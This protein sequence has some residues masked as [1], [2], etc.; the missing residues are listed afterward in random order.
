MDVAQSAPAPRIVVGIDGSPAARAALTWAL[1]EAVTWGGSVEVVHAWRDPMILVPREYD[2]VLVERDQM[3]EASRRLLSEEI[4]AV[5]A[6]AGL[7]PVTRHTARG[8]AANALIER[9]DGATLVVVGR[10]GAGGHPFLGT[11]ADQVARHAGC[12]VAVVPEG[13]PATFGRVTVG[14]DGSPQARGA[15]QWAQA[16]AGRRR[17]ALVAV[18]AW[19]LLDQKPVHGGPAFDPAYDA[20][21]ARTA[22]DEAIQDAPDVEAADIERVVVNDVPARA[23][24]RCAA[25]AD[26]MVVGARGLGGFRALLLGSVSRTLLERSPCATVVVR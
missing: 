15:L 14:V 3:D 1:D 10:T 7:V 18:M 16:E 4:A 20:G 13:T 2:P 19:G 21:V 22:L 23:L 11:I 6:A 24:L 26:L 25:H 5:G 17:V 12:P 9:S 8:S